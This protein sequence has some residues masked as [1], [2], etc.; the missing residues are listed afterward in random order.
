MG[1]FHV[2]RKEGVDAQCAARGCSRRI[3]PG[4]VHVWCGGKFESHYTKVYFCAGMIC[5]IM[6]MI[7]CVLQFVS[8]PSP[9]APPFGGVG[10]GVVWCGVAWR[11]VVWC[12]ECGLLT[13]SPTVRQQGLPCFMMSRLKN[14]YSS[15]IFP[16]IIRNSHINLSRFLRGLTPNMMRIMR[17]TWVHG[18][19]WPGCMV[20]CGLGAWRGVAWVHE[21]V[22]P[23][24]MVKCGL[25][26]W[27]GLATPTSEYAP[28]HQNMHTTP[29]KC[30]TP[31]PNVMF[32][33]GIG[34]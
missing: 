25:G 20:K 30:T 7:C 2:E 9:T 4:N 27:W 1:I 13:P 18:G 11:G 3:Y 10:G 24:C 8:C 28:T 6:G 5:F 23:G 21:G 19:V 31:T 12:D 15:S 26:A 29:Q 33:V 32:W 16:D 17:S 14:K 34:G 22:W